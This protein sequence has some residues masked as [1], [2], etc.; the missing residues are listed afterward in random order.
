MEQFLYYFVNPAVAAKALAPMWSGFKTTLA[1]IALIVPFGLA[2]GL[3]LAALRTL[4]ITWL[5][6]VI[7]GFVDFFRSVPAVVLMVVAYFGFAHLDWPISAFFTAVI[8]LVLTLA[9]FAEEIFWG[10]ILA[11]D[12]GQWE[13]SRANG[14][15]FGQTLAWVILPQ[16]VRY[17]IPPLTSRTVAVLTNT[18]VATV[19]SVEEIVYSASQQQ[20]LLAN[21]TPLTMAAVGFLLVYLPFVRLSRA[22]EQRVGAR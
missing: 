21:P 14:F 11:I 12:R 13:A 7:I 10:S 18:S 2:L 19:I 22:L 17:A 8:V 9:A 4:R 20:G 6:R 1:M 5:A 16:A 3:A 15:T